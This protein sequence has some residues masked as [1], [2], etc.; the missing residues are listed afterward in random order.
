MKFIFSAFISCFLR[1]EK[2]RMICRGN[3]RQW[4]TL[5]LSFIVQALILL[6]FS[7]AS[8]Q[9]QKLPEAKLPV[10]TTGQMLADFD[11]FVETVRQYSPQTPVRKAVTGIDPL[12]ELRRMRPRILKIKSPEEYARLIQSAIT[13]LQ[14][15]HSS[16]IP[17]NFIPP[18]EM[19]KLGISASALELL[20]A[21][22][23]LLRVEPADLKKF[24]LK[25]KYI[26]GEYYSIAPFM[27]DGV[28]FE[29][30]IKLVEVNNQKVHSFVG[31]LYPYRRM[32]RWDFDRRR[33]FSEDFYLAYNLPGSE[34]LKLKFVDKSGQA[35]TGIFKLS[36]ALQYENAAAGAIVTPAKK[37][38]YFQ[39]E[40]VLY[41]RVPKMSLEDE[42][43]YPAEIKAKAAGQPLKKIIIDIRDNPGGGDNV[44]INI[45]ASIIAKPIVFQNFVLANP[46]E[47]M[48]KKFPE[49]SAQWKSY[50][51]PFLDNYE[52]A[53]FDSGE[54]KIDPAADSLNF[55]G[56]IYILQNDGIY[57]S[58]GSLAAIGVLA[59]NI[60][61]VGQNTGRL[62][63][64]GINPMLFELPNSKIIYRI[65]PVIDFLNVRQATDV[66]HDQVEIPVALTIEQY[67]E[68]INY[69]GDVYDHE[70]LIKRDPVFI[71]ALNN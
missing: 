54:G 45:L 36:E 4:R 6:N 15:G 53:V 48:K 52:Y 27:H 59:D 1:G 31:K 41:I 60:F 8:S 20:P 69:T 32:M 44:W 24:N 3:R 47:A 64:R 49:D 26:G 30:G 61:T 11:S 2:L 43:F 66:Y 34:S 12:A 14:D 21:Y 19:K 65:E 35:K 50:R 56:K 68:R 40:Q 58:A 22:D 63:G 57:S 29:S 38:E 55:E 23:N 7:V 70:F 10:L 37:V 33:Y 28:R 67:L 17:A 13:V 46:S 39:S 16:L 42:S 71:K 18:D 25:V 5:F 51:A 9:E 62:L